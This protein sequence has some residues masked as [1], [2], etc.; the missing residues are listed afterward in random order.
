MSAAD[1]ID[2]RIKTI[3]SEA[4]G[5]NSL[6]LI[7][8][9]GG[10][11]PPFTAGAHIDLH[12]ANGLMRSYS[13]MNPQ[14]ERHRYV[15]AVNKDAASKGGSRFVHE[16]LKAGG[17]LSITAPRN[18]FPLIETASRVVLIGGG[19]GITPLWCMIQRLEE[20]GRAWELFYSTRTREMMAFRDRLEALEKKSGGRVHLNFDHEPDGKMFDLAAIV[21]AVPAD[22]HLYCCGPTP[23]LQA[24]E[25]ACKSRPPAQVHVEYF[26][27]KEEAATEGGYTV[28]LAR[29]GKTFTIPSGKTILDT[30][31][32]AK[33]D[34]P[35][36]CM[37]G[38]CGTCETKVI[39]GVPDHRDSV[40]TQ[41]EQAANKTMMICCSG[42]KS[43]KLV[44]D[45]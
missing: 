41:A 18:N 45:L 3:N 42:S 38:V 17:T 4:Q 34:V 39:E 36:S 14:G 16:N 23:M 19:I 8:A 12:L 25:A 9:A 33:I 40:L 32:D 37:Q 10:E 6:E 13:L 43:A 7:P 29:S 2:V 5:I 11:L 30:L 44:L 27:A 20:L 1:R 26:T 21:A 31:L 28:V 15:I 24:F 22:A 35:F